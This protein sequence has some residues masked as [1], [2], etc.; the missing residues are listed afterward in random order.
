MTAITAC[1]LLAAACGHDSPAACPAATTSPA[2]SADSG[3]PTTVVVPT[4]DLPMCAD[5]KGSGAPLYMPGDCKL[6]SHDSAGYTFIVRHEAESELR[7]QT[8][9]DVTGADGKVLQT[10]YT[11]PADRPA[12]PFL[13]DLVGDGRDEVV[14]QSDV[15]AVG[16]GD[17]EVYRPKSNKSGYVRAGTI[18]G[19]E[20]DR[21]ADG[22]IVSQIHGD[23]EHTYIDFDKFQA[24]QL[25][26]VAGI[27][28][29]SGKIEPP[30]SVNNGQS[31]PQ[32]ELTDAEVL[33]RFCGA[34][35]TKAEPAH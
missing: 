12:E 6:I 1:A 10:F 16:N 27:I 23:A 8:M 15:G 5:A 19:K 11:K 20:L 7:I 14:M 24:T 18:F 4:A 30:C 9:I 35:Y 26:F 13:A 17:Y 31:A 3:K 33:Q 25:V 21:T 34:Q 2:P 32:S 22:Y 28:T 29:T